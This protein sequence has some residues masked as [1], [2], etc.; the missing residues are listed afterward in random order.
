MAASLHRHD[1][2][3]RPLRR[4]QRPVRQHAAMAERIAVLRAADQR[5]GRA[6]THCVRTGVP[7]ERAVR[8]RAIAFA[9]ADVVQL[10]AGELLASLLALVVRRRGPLV[11][12]AVSPAAW[13]RWRTALAGPI[14]VGAGGAGLVVYGVAV[15]AVAPIVIGGL[16]VGGAVVLRARAWRRHW[17]SVRHRPE[18]DEIVVSRVSA[19]F[20]ADARALFAAAVHRR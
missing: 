9:R 2:A 4:G 7:T 14:V 5:A 15:G 1:H 8:I 20:E 3:G 16:A 10:V 19:G 18:R 12:I 11:V 6:P 17:I 13:R